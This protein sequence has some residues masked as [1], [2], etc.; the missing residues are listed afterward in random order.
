M[1]LVKQALHEMIEQKNHLP[2]PLM[3]ILPEFHN[4]Y[5]Q[6]FTPR[7]EETYFNQSPFFNEQGLTRYKESFYDLPSE[8]YRSFEQN[9][10][11]RQQEHI[12]LHR[13]YTHMPSYF[14]D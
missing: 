12:C 5:N 7:L 10:N 3:S 8:Q 11:P 14:F 9:F 13:N 6:S 2:P 1:Y 4:P